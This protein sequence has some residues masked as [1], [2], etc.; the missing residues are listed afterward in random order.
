MSPGG[1]N[2]IHADDTPVLL[3]ADTAWSLPWRATEEQCR[4]YAADRRV[5]GFN[6]EQSLRRRDHGGGLRRRQSVAVA[7]PPR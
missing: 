7:A 2:L 5:K 1:R 3:V 4:I 6:M